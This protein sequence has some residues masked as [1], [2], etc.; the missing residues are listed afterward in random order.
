MLWSKR[1]TC[2][3]TLKYF[4][5]NPQVFSFS[6]IH[7]REKWPRSCFCLSKGQKML[8]VGCL[9]VCLVPSN[10]MPQDLADLR[11]LLQTV[12]DYVE[13]SWK[14]NEL[15]G[16]LL[17]VP[18]CKSG[19]GFFLCIQAAP[20][21]GFVTVL[22]P[23]CNLEHN[24]LF[25]VLFKYSNLTLFNSASVI[26]ETVEIFMETEGQRLA[27]CFPVHI[28]EIQSCICLQQVKN[29]QANL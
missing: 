28:F 7:R 4:P 16:F 26:S 27:G 23:C 13:V 14:M 1:S 5:F 3:K 8:T 19:R 17:I 20:S 6:G 21:R 15:H 25:K 2:I 12:P 22:P 11:Q 10:N 18:S 9:P 24:E 29:L